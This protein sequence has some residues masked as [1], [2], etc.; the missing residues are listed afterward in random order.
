MKHIVIIDNYDS[1][2][3]NLVQ[4]VAQLQESPDITVFR[5]DAVTAGD[6]EVPGRLPS[7]LII[8]PGPCTPDE[9]GNSCDI[10]SYWAGRIPILGV[11]MGHQ[12]IA[13]AFGGQI[14]RARKCMHG[15]TSMILHDGKGI[16][17]SVPNPFIAMRYHSLIVDITRLD[18]GFVVSATTDSG[19]IM[20]IRNEALALDGVQ[21]HPESF[22]TE[23]GTT[24]L[25]N[26]LA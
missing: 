9:A 11:C 1:F 12:C 18:R 26:F 14:V 4:A 16:F 21:F 7:H 8:S 15:K 25:R 5:N 13:Q 6:L 10:I 3:Y 24:I 23:Q 22:A 19:E 2:T 20:A 17:A